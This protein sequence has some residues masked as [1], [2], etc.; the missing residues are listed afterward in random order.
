MSTAPAGWYPQEDGRQRY[1]D[2]Q[3][4]TEQF[5]PGGSPN[6]QQQD[7]HVPQAV[8]GSKRPWFKKKRVLI[9][10]GVIALTIIGSALTPDDP[11]TPVAA[12]SSASNAS[13]STATPSNTQKPVDPAAAAAKTKA[14]AEAKAKAA[15]DAKA[16]AAAK[17]KADAAA[18]AKAAADAK[19]KAAAEAKAKAAAAVAAYDGTYGKFAAITKKGHGDAIV[20]LP[21][22]AEAGLVTFSHKGSSNVA[23]SVLD[24]SNQPTGDLLVNEIG[25]YSGTSAFGLMDFGG[26]PAKIKI[27]ADGTWSIRIAPIS[28]API[29]GRSAQ[30]KGDKVFRYDGE[31]SDWAI[32]HKGSSNFAVNQVGG[33]LPNLAVNEIGNYKGVVPFIEGPSVVTVMADGS[34]SMVRK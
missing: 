23:A 14:D 3:Q 27:T 20:A 12:T 29:L 19:A 31:G 1:W 4:W 5:A 22:G 32:T 9:P 34:W 2:G 30:G 28:S 18:K 15:A 8:S 13:D 16:A 33:L 10:A 7:A 11:T 24:K 26:D 17:A 21:K 6:M 25:N